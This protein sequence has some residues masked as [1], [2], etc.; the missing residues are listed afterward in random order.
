VTACGVLRIGIICPMT[1]DEL[2][3]K[4]RKLNTGATADVVIADAEGQYWPLAFEWSRIRTEG[5]PP[6]EHDFDAMN[7]LVLMPERSSE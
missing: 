4:L 2:I 7:A 1:V 5:E 6:Y 3:D